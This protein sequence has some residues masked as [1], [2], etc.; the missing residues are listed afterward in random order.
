MFSL[1]LAGGSFMW[2]LLVILLVVVVLAI[3]KGAQLFS[4]KE[5]NIK[6]LENGVNA[7]LF[8]G[9]YGVVVGLF[10]HFLGILYAMEAIKRAADIS[11][12]IVAGGYSI[13]LLTILFGLIIF[14]IAAIIWFIYK[15]VLAR[16]D[17]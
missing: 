13:S 9:I 16:L 10:A 6:K 7:I 4:N 11:P 8:W 15:S 17:V 5:K 2:L 14:M 3:T 1:F 12:A